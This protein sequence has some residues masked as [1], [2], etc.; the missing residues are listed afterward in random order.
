[1]WARLRTGVFRLQ[2]YKYFEIQWLGRVPGRI[3]SHNG[4]P[5]PEVPQHD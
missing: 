1:M 2:E 4:P 5:D 3:A